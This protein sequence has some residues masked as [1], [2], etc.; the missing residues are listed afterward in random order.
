M[1]IGS[2]N[3]S[4]AII[5]AFSAVPPTPMPIIPGGHHPAPIFEIVV[6]IQSTKLSLGFSTINLALFSEPAPLAAI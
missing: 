2:I 4:F 6:K 1:L 3:D 5:I